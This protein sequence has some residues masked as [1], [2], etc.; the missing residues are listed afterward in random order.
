MSAGK[1]WGDLLLSDKLLEENPTMNP[2]EC[3]GENSS[4]AAAIA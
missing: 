1:P 2:V 4:L 3:L